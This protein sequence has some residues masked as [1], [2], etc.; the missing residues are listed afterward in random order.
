MNSK[1]YT[2]SLQPKF[3]I[4]V[5]FGNLNPHPISTHAHVQIKATPKSI[6]NYILLLVKTLHFLLSMALLSITFLT[7]S[8]VLNIPLSFNTL[9]IVSTFPCL[10]NSITKNIA[11]PN[12]PH[13]FASEFQPRF[14]L[15]RLNTCQ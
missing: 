12:D 5:D 1:D 6:Y 9:L 14:Q 13:M 10:F 7:S 8:F 15:T 3:E 4:T 11:E 2:N